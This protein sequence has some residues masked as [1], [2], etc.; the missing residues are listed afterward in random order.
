MGPS[1]YKRPTV[2]YPDQ[3]S[4]EIVERS[5]SGRARK[6]RDTKTGETWT[7]YELQKAR[8][9]GLTPQAAA[10]A[11]KLG[12]SESLQRAR[13]YA[14]DLEYL[15]GRYADRK[16]TSKRDALKDSAFYDSLNRFTREYAERKREKRS[17]LGRHKRGRRGKR[18]R[19]RGGGGEGGGGGGGEGGG[20]GG[21]GD[22]FGGGRR[23]RDILEDFGYDD[24]DDYD[25]S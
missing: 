14:L 7:Q 16:G 18:K 23:M 25:G 6:Y 22:L 19:R 12:G 21:Q 10:K 1:K 3:R 13:T 24:I 15:A 11:R 5:P 2:T 8:N 9:G 4:L 17:G 20:G